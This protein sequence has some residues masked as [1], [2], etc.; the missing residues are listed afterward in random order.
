MT[1]FYDDRFN[2]NEWFVL[3]LLL[4]YAI[5]FFLP[6]RFPPLISSLF[7]LF[8]ISSA[9]FM[10]HAVGIKPI[11]FYDVNDSSRYTIM[12]FLLY[13]AYGPFSYLIIYLFDKFKLKKQHSLFYIPACSA[14]ALGFEWLA[15][16]LGVFHYKNGYQVQYSFPIYLVIFSILLALYFKLWIQKN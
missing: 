16:Q 11:D 2:Q 3:M 12:D 8:G 9:L 4:S 15:D 10:D 6:R 13:C 1:V 5:V 7:L 14:I